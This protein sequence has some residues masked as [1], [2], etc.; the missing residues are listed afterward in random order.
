MVRISGHAAGGHARQ[1]LGGQEKM[2]VPTTNTDANKGE[3]A[4]VHMYTGK[5]KLFI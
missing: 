1:G 2:K 5:L 3:E 4:D